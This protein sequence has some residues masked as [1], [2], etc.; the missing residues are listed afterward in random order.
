MFAVLGVRSSITPNAARRPLFAE[1]NVDVAAFYREARAALPPRAK[2]LLFREVRGYGASFDY[3]WGDPM[4][5]TLIDYRRIADP[6]ALARRLQALGLT[7]VLD[8]P[9]SHL[10]REDPGYYDARTLGLMAECLKRRARLMLTREGLA[11]HE[12][13]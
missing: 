7:H 13:L 5:Q 1:R 10:Y 8:H 11:L 6:D 9:G 4:N 2:V 12:L 3:L